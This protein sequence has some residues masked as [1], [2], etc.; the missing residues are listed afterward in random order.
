MKSEKQQ[1]L[2]QLNKDLDLWLSK[3]NAERAKLLLSK[4]VYIFTEKER[5]QSLSGWRRALLTARLW[6]I[7]VKWYLYDIFVNSTAGRELF[8]WFAELGTFTATLE[9]VKQDY[10]NNPNIR[11]GILHQARYNRAKQICEILNLFDPNHC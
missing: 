10:K 5:M 4:F 1:R 2:D 7:A 8:V 3:K 9:R 6:P 11:D